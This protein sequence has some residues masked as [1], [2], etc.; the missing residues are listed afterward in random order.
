MPVE[1]VRIDLLLLECVGQVIRTT[2]EPR[3]GIRLWDGGLRDVMAAKLSEMGISN[4]PMT[5]VDLARVAGVLGPDP[6]CIEV[7]PRKR[8][9]RGL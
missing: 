8:G 9:C 1:G 6:N 4:Q 2:V 3:T 5:L 7:N